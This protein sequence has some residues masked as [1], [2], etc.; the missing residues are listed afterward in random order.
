M[1]VDFLGGSPSSL[2]L[3]GAPR[4]IRGLERVKILSPHYV[5]VSDDDIHCITLSKKK[6]AAA[7]TEK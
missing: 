6:D 5:G 3:V 4:I 2:L 7:R 1:V